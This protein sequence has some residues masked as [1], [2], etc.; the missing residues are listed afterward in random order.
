MSAPEGWR[1]SKRIGAPVP[2]TPGLAKSPLTA[3]RP[4]GAHGTC[5]STVLPVFLLSSRTRRVPSFTTPFPPMYSCSSVTNAAAA[6]V[7]LPQ[8]PPHSTAP[9]VTD[10][11]AKEYVASYSCVPPSRGGG[12]MITAFDVDDVPPPIPSSCLRYSSSGAPI[13]AASTS[14][15]V[16]PEGM[17]PSDCPNK[18]AQAGGRHAGSQRHTT[19]RTVGQRHRQRR[20][21]ARGR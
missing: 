15:H 13:A 12:A 1:N 14:S 16:T 5:A 6:A 9:V 11:C 8:F 18:G 21:P 7:R 4:S 2:G 10:I 17:I 3:Y 20:S 19:S